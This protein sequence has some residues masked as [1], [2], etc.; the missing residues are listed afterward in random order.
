[1][2]ENS[3]P[4]IVAVDVETTGLYP[5]QEDRICEI[6]LLRIKNNNLI[7]KFVTL[8]N[9]EREISYS[10]YLVNGITNQM[11]KNAPR[12]SE[13]AEDVFNFIEDRIL[14]IHN[15][16]F[17]LSFLDYELKRSGLY[18][19]RFKLIDTLK[20]ARR[21]FEFPSNSLQN[22]ASY[23]EIPQKNF[24]RAE[25]DA[26]TAYMVFLLLYDELKKR[27]IYLENLLSTIEDV[28][29]YLKPEDILPP[30]ILKN[31]GKGEKIKIRYIGRSGETLRE[32]YP[33]QIIKERGVY[34][35]VAFCCL[36]KEERKFRLD[37]I[38]EV[39]ENIE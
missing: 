9:P 13:I 4:E 18:L 35:L 23:L 33:L 28:E 29:R 34:Y 7:E 24:H 22:L 17:D 11:V 10:A 21:F 1:M 36:R 27:K 6:A 30:S 14:L 20:I 2:E 31:L 5:E 25:S 19:P 37:R 26:W 15:A 8:V 12:F 39:M 16:S 38:L 3:I 32:I